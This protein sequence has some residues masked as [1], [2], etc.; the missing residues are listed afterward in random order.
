MATTAM[1]TAHTCVPDSCRVVARVRGGRIV[2]CVCGNTFKE[3]PDHT[4][5]QP[6]QVRGSMAFTTDEYEMV[7]INA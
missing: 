7:I 5:L 3:L 1:S 6:G 4:L 2:R